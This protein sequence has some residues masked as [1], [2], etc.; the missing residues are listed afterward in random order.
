MRNLVL[1]TCFLFLLTG[2]LVRSP[3]PEDIKKEVQANYRKYEEEIS[4]FNEEKLSLQKQIVIL[5]KT[6][7][8]M[9]KDLGEVKKLLA[10]T[11]M[12]CQ[13]LEE[14][15]EKETV[16]VAITPAATITTTRLIAPDYLIETRISAVNLKSDLVIL[17]IGV[18]DQVKVGMKFMVSRDGEV[19]GEITVNLVEEDWSSARIIR[20]DNDFY[21]G[22]KVILK[23]E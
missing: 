12:R 9:Q 22:D 19:V 17:L 23:V 16:A 5:E 4:Q 14:R 7:E 10:D 18:N 13:E 2:C 1:I 15:L 8:E 6:V 3:L 11:Q 20:Q 21:V